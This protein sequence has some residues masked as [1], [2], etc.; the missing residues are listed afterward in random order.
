MWAIIGGSGFEKFDAFET[1]ELLP[2]ETPFG[3]ASSGIKHVR[4]TDGDKKYEALF[5]SRHGEH[6]ENLPS[7][8][9]FRA[10]IFALKRAGAKAI[11]SFSAVGSLRKEFKPGDCVVPT[12]YI[13]RTKGVRAHTFLGEGLVGHVSLAKPVC[14]EGVEGLREI[15]KKY[16]DFDC[17][18]G[19]TYVCIEGPYFSTKAEAAYHRMI[20]ADIIG[21][22]HFPEY[23][24]AR[25]AGLAYLPCCFITDYDCWDDS[26]P[27]VTLEE[28]IQ[29]MR[30]NNAKAFRMAQDILATGD[31]FYQAARTW[32][33]GLRT[34]LMTP[35]DQIPQSKAGWLEVLMAQ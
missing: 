34:G 35:K 22:T 2:R 4:I 29:V 7:E 6:H 24:L 9:N 26:I 13:D 21:M 14:M 12:S 33:H 19:Q 8:V 15:A 16:K 32:E 5:V 25:E 17:H 11:M 10:N 3:L 30:K 28:V 27:H 1:I 31:Q 20:G 18:F 23:A